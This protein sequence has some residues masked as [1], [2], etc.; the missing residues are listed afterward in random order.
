MTYQAC[1]VDLFRYYAADIAQEAP[2]FAE[3]LPQVLGVSLLLPNG[4]D[5]TT[6]PVRISRELADLLVEAELVE[7]EGVTHMGPMLPN[8]EAEP[9]HERHQGVPKK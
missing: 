9:N 7:V 3:G 6:T 4:A 8:K 2:S 1:K 5:D